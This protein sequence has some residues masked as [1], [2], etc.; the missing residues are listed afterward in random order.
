MS[1]TVVAGFRLV[2]PALTL[3]LL[4]TLSAQAP[5]GGGSFA[6]R[7]LLETTFAGWSSPAAFLPLVNSAGGL[8]GFVANNCGNAAPGMQVNCA[9]PT[10]G[11]T[12]GRLVLSS[13]TWDP[14]TDCADCPVTTVSFRLDHRNGTT[15]APGHSVWPA[16]VQGASLYVGPA[17]PAFS[18]PWATIAAPWTSLPTTSF[19]LVTGATALGLSTNCLSNP[20][21]SCSGAALSFG[22]LVTVTAL[23]ATNRTHCYDNFRVVLECPAS[24]STFCTGCA[25][26]GVLPPAIGYSGGLPFIGNLS[27][28]I[29]ETGACP[30]VPT[31]LI[32]G[33]SNTTFSGGA[34]PF[35]LLSLGYPACNLCVSPDI[36]LIAITDALGNASA[37][38]PIQDNVYLIGAKF[39][40]QWLDIGPP[41][42]GMSDAAKVV[43]GI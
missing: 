24:F 30:L 32:L 21:F 18:A 5:S 14:A 23:G 26:C 15:V 39:Y 34:L 40:A 43:I 4:S 19:C 2:W 6:N 22:F 33:T 27:F 11:G 13:A 31:V 10:A 8:S 3:G 28:T 35:N 37:S 29:T 16:I 1:S 25:N 7:V 9:T 36:L 41:P 42:I 38:L 17:A 20:D 12:A